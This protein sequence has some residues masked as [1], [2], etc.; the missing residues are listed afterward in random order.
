MKKVF[1]LLLSLILIFALSACG[2]EDTSSD[3]DTSAPT[4][5]TETTSEPADNSSEEDTDK[6]TEGGTSDTDTPTENSKPTNNSKPTDTSSKPST[7]PSTSTTSKPT[8]TSKPTTSTSSLPSTHTHNWSIDWKTKVKAFVGKD[9]IETRTCETCKET[10]E[11]ST[12]NNAMYNSFYDDS[13]KCFL[14]TNDLGGF[15]KWVSYFTNA[16]DERE[17][18]TITPSSTAV[19]AW[20]SARFVLT[21][22]IKADMKQDPRY[23]TTTDN[24]VLPYDNWASSP[25]LVGYIH[26]GGNKYTVYYQHFGNESDNIKVELEYNL[27]NNKPNKYISIEN[28]TSIP[29]NITK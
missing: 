16:Y 21:D 14:T 12:K 7:T 8:E 26:N 23:D 25:T 27:L 19:F 13:L 6:E 22:S 20:M 29:S 9:G 1:A 5:T 17:A 3:T 28:V 24:F 4:S 15:S 10:E 18:E 11:R 2:K